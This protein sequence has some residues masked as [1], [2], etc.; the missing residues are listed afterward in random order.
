MQKEIIGNATLYCGSFLDIDDRA[1]F[2]LAHGINF[3]VADPPYGISFKKN[4]DNNKIPSAFFGKAVVG[5]DV[6][7]D[8]S[9][10]LALG[11]PM[12]LWGANHY[13]QTLPPSA[14]WI[15]WDK[16]S[17]SHH[18]NDFADCE[19]AWT[20]LKG[21]ARMLRHNWDG[22]LRD[23]ERGIPRLHPTQK[24]IAAM[25]F[26]ISMKPESTCILDAYMGSGTTAV[27]ALKMSK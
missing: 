23:S 22:F 7:F 20:N 25:E 18:S 6:P 14:S 16:R 19:L 11:L 21:P 9:H 5:D 15:A 2:V 17:A 12:I 26:F 10:L 8:P 3:I 13:A 24:P 4:K 27:A 1:A